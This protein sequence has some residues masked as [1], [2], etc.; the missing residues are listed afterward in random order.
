M[1]RLIQIYISHAPTQ[2]AR[3]K[4]DRLLVNLK[5][6][7][8]RGRVEV[9]HRDS[10]RPSEELDDELRRFVGAADIFVPLLSADWLADDMCHEVELVEA[11]NQKAS[12]ALVIWPIRVEKFVVEPG[13][14]AAPLTRLVGFPA[15]HIESMAALDENQQQGVWVEVLTALKPLF[16]KPDKEKSDARSLKKGYGRDKQRSA[17]L[18]PIE[19]RFALIVGVN[20]FADATALRYSAADARRLTDTLVPLGYKVHSL[21]DQHPDG[22]R[23]LPTRQN[24]EAELAVLCKNAAAADFLFVHIGTHGLLG[25]GP[26]KKTYLLA[27]DTRVDKLAESALSVEKLE[28][29]LLDSKARRVVLSIDACHSGAVFKDS[30][31]AAEPKISLT[32]F[33]NQVYDKAEG[34]AVIAAC[35][36]E[37]VAYEDPETGLGAYTRFLV[38]ALEGRYSLDGGSCPRDNKG[39]VTVD[40]VKNYVLFK[41]R[42]WCVRHGKLPQAPNVRSEMLGDLILADYRT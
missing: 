21:F 36:A 2:A 1:D 41:M 10:A 8:R 38:E 32:D 20:E 33:Y 3:N 28:D 42:E 9:K 11:L 30:R 34:L 15:P 26:D 5:P 19:H 14:P 27:Q 29:M 23:F 18:G 22:V 31:R 7:M 39:V 35:T 24:I 40:A 6:L 17:E 37:Q 25:P 16:D 13:D 12:G 4:R